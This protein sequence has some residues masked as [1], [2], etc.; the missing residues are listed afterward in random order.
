MSKSKLDRAKAV[1]W[2]ML[3]QVG[4]VV[5]RRWTGISEKDRARLTE[6]VRESRGRIGNLS[7]REQRELRKLAGRLD[8]KGMGREL[9]PVVL[10]GLKRR[11]RR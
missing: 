9:T 7:S 6:L 10:A 1:P 2:L 3:L 8:L 5:G 4:V 11:K